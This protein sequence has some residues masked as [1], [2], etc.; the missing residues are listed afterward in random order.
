MLRGTMDVDLTAISTLGVTTA[1]AIVPDF[2]TLPSAQHF[3]SWPG[4]VPETRIRRRR[5]APVSGPERPRPE[6]GMPRC[7]GTVPRPEEV[8]RPEHRHRAARR[9][10]GPSGT[11]CRRLPL[12]RRGRQAPRT[13]RP[14]PNG[15][16]RRPCRGPRPRPLAGRPGTGPRRIRVHRRSWQSGSHA[17]SIGA[18]LSVPVQRH[19][20]DTGNALPHRPVRARLSPDMEKPRSARR[21]LAESA[22]SG[23]VTGVGLKNVV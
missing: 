5:P 8:D 3:R 14:G 22:G 4:L 17:V 19:L 16:C 2:Y 13:R 10:P 9:D 11:S 1:L 15:P 23:A 7:P 18:F 20:F 21:I 12:H 6:P